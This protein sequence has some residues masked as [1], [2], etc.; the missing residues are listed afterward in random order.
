MDDQY[1]DF[2]LHVGPGGHV[3]ARSNQGE[4]S[5]VIPVGVPG[6]IL[7]T[8]DL[9]EKDQT[10][11]TLLKHLGKRLYEIILPHPI[12]TL[13]NVTEAVARS[14][15]RKIRTRLTIEPDA[16]A[17][18]PWEF[19]YREEMG[20]F[21]A[22]NPDT[23]L[24]RYLDLPL[25]AG[26]IRRRE[27]PLHMLIIISDPS[28]QIRL[29]PDE[30]ERMILKA[31]HRPRQDGLITTTTV[32]RAIYDEIYEALLAR[33]P[34]I[35]Q[36][37]GHGIY[38]NGKGYLLLVNKETNKTWEVDDE[39]FADIFLGFNRRLG[40]VNLATCESAKSE[41]Q[42]SFV[43]IAPKIV[44]MGV[45]AVVAM[46]YNVLISTAEI[47][48]ENFYKS[49]AGRKPVDWAVQ[50]ARNAISIIEGLDNREFATPVLYMR[51]EDGNI[52]E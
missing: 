48:L 23:V 51:A 33:Q 52:F 11:G 42:R 19:T 39:R 46:Q 7:L 30:W 41:S 14:Q 31:L 37:V 49:V 38:R 18:L 16:L 3:R 50:Q 28:D 32:K 1:I 35:I 9:I 27:G 25:P 12:H 40:L 4:Q 24:S 2:N 44:Q 45:P 8:L 22:A 13:F 21:L 26:Y 43:G 5:A 10:D 29:N 36:F 34:D 20:Y 15:Q 17:S 47:F 6:D